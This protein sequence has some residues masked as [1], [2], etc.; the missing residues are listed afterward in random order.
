MAETTPMPIGGY[1]NGKIQ[2]ADCL[3]SE[4]E[5][6]M[7]LFTD[8]DR[9]WGSG[10]MI[11]MIVETG[12]HMNRLY[13]GKDRLQV[14]DIGAKEGG[15]I[16][17][18]GSHQNGLDVDLEYFKAD[19]IEHVPTNAQLYAPSMVVD[20]KVSKNFDIERNWE[21]VKALH[22]YGSVQRIFMDQKLKNE[23]CKFAKSSGDYAAHSKVLQSIRH[24][25]N[26]QDHIHVRLRCPKNATR[27]IPQADPPAGTGCP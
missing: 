15:E 24:E 27:C 13:P 21:F 17:G 5:G 3:I 2:D 8:W 22:K 16:E 26:H 9:I 11:K 25:T 14:E 23:L 1:T 4:G 19:G 12:A 20:N 18:H 6:Y 10:P 7:Q